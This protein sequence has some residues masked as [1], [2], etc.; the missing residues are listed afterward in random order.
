LRLVKQGTAVDFNLA[1]K[2]I[3]KN[4][5]ARLGG[6]QGEPLTSLG[7]S[8]A[9]IVAEM[10]KTENEKLKLKF[11]KHVSFQRTK[12]GGLFIIRGFKGENRVCRK[13][14]YGPSKHSPIFTIEDAYSKTL[15]AYN[16]IFS[17]GTPSSVGM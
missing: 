16:S 14:S 6:L 3:L 4:K 11:V 8:C 10:S 2:R 15:E 1:K 17:T 7:P 12:K 9:E 5:K 13:V